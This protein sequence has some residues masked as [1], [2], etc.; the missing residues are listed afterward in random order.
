M[1]EAAL[2]RIP[3]LENLPIFDADSEEARDILNR[4]PAELAEAGNTVR[5]HDILHRAEY[6]PLAAVRKN[7]EVR[8]YFETLDH[9]PV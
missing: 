1:N 5:L 9:A 2:R 3:R 8:V 6:K 7:G 4:A